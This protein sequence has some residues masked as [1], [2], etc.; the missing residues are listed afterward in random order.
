MLSNINMKPHR[1]SICASILLV[2]SVA[3]SQVVL[4]LPI[5]MYAQHILMV[6]SNVLHGISLIYSQREKVY[7]EAN[8]T[9]GGSSTIIMP[10]LTPMLP[11]PQPTPMVGYPIQND[12]LQVVTQP[13][14]FVCPTFTNNA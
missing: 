8:D 5:P 12:P 3:I 2:V 14:T 9:N 1:F 4:E 11:Q 6:T 13:A 7:D 10:P